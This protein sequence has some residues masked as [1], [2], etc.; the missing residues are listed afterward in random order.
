VKITRT[1]YDVCVNIICIAVLLGTVIWLC[2][3]W[4]NIP[5]KIPGHYN[6]YGVVDR[7]GSKKELLIPPI[8][9]WIMYV[10]LTLVGNFPEIWNTGVKVTVQNRERIYRVLKDMLETMK[11]LF[12]AIFSFLTINSSLSRSLSVWFL[13][14]ALCLVFGIFVFLGI[15]LVKAK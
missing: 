9:A 1:W 12:V 11:L 14:V 8:V 3:S 6:I 4:S 10:G 15:R 7:W 5:E 2:L 13:P